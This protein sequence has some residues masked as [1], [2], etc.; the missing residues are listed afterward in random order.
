[1]R[2]RTCFDPA[3]EHPVAV[4]AFVASSRQGSAVGSPRGS[5]PAF[6]GRHFRPG[7]S[8]RR[9]SKGTTSE[10][11]IDRAVSPRR[12]VRSAGRRVRHEPNRLLRRG[13]SLRDR[14]AHERDPVVARALV[15]TRSR[16][17]SVVSARAATRVQRVRRDHAP[18]ARRSCLGIRCRVPGNGTRARLHDVRPNARARNAAHTRSG[19]NRRL[20]GQP[21]HRPVRELVVLQ[22]SGRSDALRRGPVL[23]TLCQNATDWVRGRVRK[24]VVVARADARVVP[25]VVRTRRRFVRA[26]RVPSREVAPRLCRS[27]GAARARC[28][29]VREESD[30]V[31]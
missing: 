28:R 23:R 22:L 13:R 20:R 2:P 15:A 29:V 5:P 12:I 31:R 14:V 30:P 6:Q 7:P 21:H 3:V 10:G 11:D 4:D 24:H 26:L 18:C 19:G 17:E 1:M 27:H 8:I 9:S 25:L 16:A